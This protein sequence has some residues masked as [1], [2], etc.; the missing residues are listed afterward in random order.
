M[1]ERN[2]FN[3]IFIECLEGLAFNIYNSTINVAVLKIIFN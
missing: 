3:F 1:P 2:F